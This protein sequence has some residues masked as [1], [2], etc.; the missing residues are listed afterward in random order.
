MR[1]AAIGDAVWRGLL[2]RGETEY[3]KFSILWFTSMEVADR[4]GLVLRHY[5]PTYS[6]LNSFALLAANSLVRWRP[7]KLNPWSRAIHEGNQM[8]KIIP[9]ICLT[10]AM[11]NP[12]CA[13][14]IA[15]QCAGTLKFD[16]KTLDQNLLATL[17]VLRTISESNY[18]NMKSGGAFEAI[19]GYG[20]F[21]GNYQEAK[22]KAHEYES[23]FSQDQLTAA[24][25]KFFSQTLSPEGARAYAECIRGV[26][27]API[28]AWIE[29]T[30]TR[31]PVIV[32]VKL[33]DAWTSANISVTGPTPDTAPAPLVG[34]GSED[35]M[36]FEH[37]PSQPFSVTIKATN[38]QTNQTRTET[39]EQAGYRS[40][41]VTSSYVTD[42]GWVTCAAGCN[43]NTSGCSTSTGYT[44]VAP[45]HFRYDE[46]TLAPDYSQAKF[47]GGPGVKL[48][49]NVFPEK[50]ETRNSAGELVR[51]T[52]TPRQCEGNSGD[53][54]GTTTFP[55]SIRRIGETVVEQ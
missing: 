27:G 18:E 13:E 29:N 9:I 28:S 5:C 51:L 55:Y 50:S 41:K 52:V 26:S 16:T 30:E 6:Q 35:T 7:R 2:H 46:S 8:R 32:K 24:S 25:S 45:P 39:L 4:D 44:F 33:G 21:S 42:T 3:W 10:L 17:S 20:M 38:P 34:G 14:S 54:Q 31:N 19:T 23:M 43:G 15:S 36:R 22:A 47:L 49:S 11:A 1:T 53:T 48:N 40:F 37:T 12:A